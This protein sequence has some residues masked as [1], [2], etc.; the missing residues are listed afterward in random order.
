MTNWLYLIA[1]P[2]LHAVLIT[3]YTTIRDVMKWSNCK[4]LTAD[5]INVF[6]DPFHCRGFK[7]TCLKQFD[8]TEINGACKGHLLPSEIKKLPFEKYKELIESENIVNISCLTDNLEDFHE[9]L[10][11]FPPTYAYYCSHD[12]RWKTTLATMLHQK[13]MTAA[14]F[15]TPLLASF[16]SEP[17]NISQLGPEFFKNFQEIELEPSELSLLTKEQFKYVAFANWSAEKVRAVP[18]EYFD[19]FNQADSIPFWRVDTLNSLTV[20][21]VSNWGRHPSELPV[22]GK[23]ARR[24]FYL[25]HPCTYLRTILDRFHDDDV[26]KAIKERCSPLWKQRDFIKADIRNRN[27]RRYNQDKFQAR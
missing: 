7:A 26:V 21:H 14:S 16:L 25:A 4:T 27:Y 22:R 11:S 13:G 5:A 18:P 19:V 2:I 20:A 9:S 24:T 17:K 1:L 23:F 12:D 10:E 8:L 6:L 3:E 15:R